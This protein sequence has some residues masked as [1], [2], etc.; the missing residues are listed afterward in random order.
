MKRLVGNQLTIDTEYG[1]KSCPFDRSMYDEMAGNLSWI[2]VVDDESYLGDPSVIADLDYMCVQAFKE[3]YLLD[4]TDAYYAWSE[5]SNEV[6]AHWIMGANLE[7]CRKFLIEVD[8]SEEPRPITYPERS[9]EI[10]KARQEFSKLCEEL[11][12]PMAILREQIAREWDNLVEIV[13]KNRTISPMREQLKALAL[14]GSHFPQQQTLK[15]TDVHYTIKPSDM[16]D[17]SEA[18]SEIVSEN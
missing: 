5:Y 7:A 8:V 11:R 16:D 13:R 1:D 12:E 9:E 3:G 15:N 2:N 4:R 17:V 14:I 6:S 10:E 18:I